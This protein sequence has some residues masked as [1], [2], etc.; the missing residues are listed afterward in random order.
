ML[1]MNVAE[2]AFP[3]LLWRPGYIYLASTALELCSHPRFGFRDTVARARRGEWHLAD[4]E[5]TCYQVSDWRRVKPFGGLRSLG[6]LLT[7]TIFAEPIL[8]GG[9]APDLAEF[10]RL[11]ERAVRGRY[12]FDKETLARDDTIEGIRKAQSTREAMNAL[13]AR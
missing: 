11:L 4:A 3:A 7:G 6:L 8:A 13:P 9:R 1:A 5:G 10:K 12:E 2:I